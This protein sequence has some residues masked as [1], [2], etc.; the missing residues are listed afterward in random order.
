MG[1]SR[2]VQAFP[3]F[4]E[5]FGRALPSPGSTARHLACTGPIA[6]KGH[7]ILAPTSSACRGAPRR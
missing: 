1:P 5:W 7:A 6:Y 3:D 4:Y 2:E